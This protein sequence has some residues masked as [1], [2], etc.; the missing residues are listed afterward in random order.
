[1]QYFE[2]DEIMATVC[3]AV[4]DPASGQLAVSLAGHLPPVI[5]APGQHC[6]LAE[7]AAD[8]PIGTTD[9]SRREVTTLTLVPGT[10]LCLYTDG[11]V[12]RR[13]EPI[14][15]GIRPVPGGDGRAA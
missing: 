12:E 7:I 8:L 11:L 10:V 6:A 15:D 9:P 3:Y 1:M 4:L 13:D 14:D 5:A 2:E